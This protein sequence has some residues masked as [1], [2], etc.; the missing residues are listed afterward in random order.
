MSL[1]E[2]N[3][4]PFQSSSLD[5]TYKQ[6]TSSLT[7]TWIDPDFPHCIGSITK[8]STEKEV[9]SSVVWKKPIDFF[10]KNQNKIYVFDKVEANDVI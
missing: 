9:F 3:K 2:I 7:T 10:P 5:L 4:V 8:S 1:Q 6:I